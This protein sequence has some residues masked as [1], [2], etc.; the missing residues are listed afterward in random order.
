MAREAGP[1]V[2]RRPECGRRV[3][4]YE[5]RGPS[6][7]S[8]VATEERLAELDGA[9]VEIMRQIDK[10]GLP[11]AEGTSERATLASFIAQQVTRTPEQRGRV[12]FARDLAD[13]AGE[14]EI[15]TTVVAE[16]LEHVHLGFCPSDS[17][18]RAALDFAHVALRDPSLLTKEFA[19]QVMLQAVSELAPVL[20]GRYWTLEIARKPRLLTSDTPVVIWRKPTPR[21][22]YEGVGIANA[23]E[24]RFPLD[25]RKQL[26]LTSTARP[27]VRAIEPSRVRACNGDIASGCHRFIV[28]NPNWR[29][30][31]QEVTLKPKRPVVRFN[32]APFYER[33]PGGAMI[34]TG[35]EMLHM[36]VP[37]R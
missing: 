13:Y 11:S 14:R 25:P 15:D 32:I 34:F 28:G 35:K 31:L 8:S 30:P 10:T 1:P 24:V 16:Y 3:R 36:W 7:G 26:V 6:G 2:D 9:A 37:R 19:V 23:E 33:G 5:T 29:R 22:R 4:I 20:L 21:D 12:L 18:V 17:E 27:L